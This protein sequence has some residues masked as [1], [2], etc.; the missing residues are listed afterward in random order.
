M[1]ASARLGICVMPGLL[2]W[3]CKGSGAASWLR[4]NAVAVPET[5]NTWV[6]LDARRLV[7]R[8]GETEFLLVGVGRP[9]NLAPRVYPVLREDV[10]IALVGEGAEAVLLETCSFDFAQ[11]DGVSQLAMTSIAG[12]SAVAIKQARPL[13]TVRLWVDPTFGPYLWATLLAIVR[14]LGGREIEPGPAVPAA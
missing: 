2:K 11:L 3:G 14:E 1:S 10:E 4:D 5:P 9:A 12:V 7:A 6:A 13:P 8:L